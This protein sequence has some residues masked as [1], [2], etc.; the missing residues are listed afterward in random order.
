MQGRQ[1]SCRWSTGSDSRFCDSESVKGQPSSDICR[2]SLSDGRVSGKKSDNGDART[3]LD[4]LRSF[5]TRG[6]IRERGQVRVRPCRPG[7]CN[8]R[9]CEVGADPR[10]GD[11]FESS[12]RVRDTRQK[13][14]F[15]R[16]TGTI[17]ASRACVLSGVPGSSGT[18]AAS[19][20]PPL[21]HHDADCWAKSRP[22]RNSLNISNALC[23]PTSGMS[24]V[25]DVS[26]CLS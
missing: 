10:K 13:V 23:P 19:S 16:K 22:A 24:S 9:G 3:T 15:C 6:P 21:P 25:S 17:Q 8:A 20:S 5:G 11:G 12:D 26:C 1:S 2:K 7:C 4:T 14:S 18:V